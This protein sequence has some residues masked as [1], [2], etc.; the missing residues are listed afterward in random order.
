MSIRRQDVVITDEASNRHAPAIFTRGRFRSG[1][2]C[3]SSGRNGLEQL[4]S[5]TALCLLAAYPWLRHLL[6]AEPRAKPLLLLSVILP[7]WIN[8]LIRTYALDRG[9]PPPMGFVNYGWL[10]LR[11]SRT[12]RP[13]RPFQPLQLLN[14]RL[15]G[16][17]RL[18]Y[19]TCPFMVLPLYA[20]VERLDTVLSRAS[21][22][23]GASQTDFIS[24]TL[25]LTI[26]GYR[27]RIILVFIPCPRF[28][29]HADHSAA[30]NAVMIG[31]V[32]ERSS[33]RPMTG[34]SG[35]AV[36]VCSCTPPSSPRI[37]SLRRRK[38]GM[39][40]SQAPRQPRPSRRRGRFDAAW[41][42]AA[43]R[44]A[45]TTA[46]HLAKVQIG[47]VFVMLYAPILA[48]IAF[49][50]NDSRRN[51]VWQGFTTKYYL[52]A[53]ENQALIAAMANSLT[54]ALALHALRHRHR[55]GDGAA[56]VALPLSLQAAFEGFMALPIVIPEILHGRGA[57]R[58]LRRVG[59]FTSSFES[60]PIAWW[61]SLFTLWPLNLS[62]ITISHIAFS[63][64]F[65]AVVVRAR[66]TGFNRELDEASRDLGASEWQT[67]ATSSCPFMRPG[68]IAGAL[69]A[70]TLSLDDFVIT[71]SLPGRRR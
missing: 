21:L 50:F 54:I 32:I 56:A 43:S 27:L 28:L 31:N 44:T 8:L 5:T 2:I 4:C 53:W 15:R 6:C 65:V 33:R 40:S 47:A 23:L 61:N 45:R 69:L 35:G 60:G 63:F 19:V 66:M 67:F 9:Y 16:D 24:V 17:R 20:T 57:A 52:V 18:V 64:P 25:P 26:P 29:S 1:P 59:R 49:S 62:A 36:L 3:R 48:L 30:P 71:F 70:F 13:S 55:R 39:S 58:L 22:D 68:L 14:H 38:S 10:H 42:S 34:R 46:R 7:F 41:A 12:H 37:R 51:V 11:P